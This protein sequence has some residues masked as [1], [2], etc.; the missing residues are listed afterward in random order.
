MLSNIRN[1]GVFRTYPFLAA[2]FLLVFSL[3]YLGWQI[4][5]IGI[6][7]YLTA[8]KPDEF[9]VYWAAW[10]GEYAESMSKK[11]RYPSG[12][13]EI[14]FQIH[15]YNQGKPLRLDPGT[16]KNGI[17]IKGVSFSRFGS[18]RFITG[19]QLEDLIEKRSDA[20][21][22]TSDDE[23]EVTFDAVDPQLYL[24]GFPEPLPAWHQFCALVLTCLLFCLLAKRLLGKQTVFEKPRLFG[25]SLA[26]TILGRL[27]WFPFYPMLAISTLLALTGICVIFSPRAVHTISL[28]S[29]SVKAVMITGCFLCL[30]GYPLLRAV[31]PGSKFLHAAGSI[32]GQTTS[33]SSLED[34]HSGVKKAIKELDQSFIQLF[35]FR[36]DLLNLNATIK[37]FGLGFSPTSKA[38]LGKDGMFFEGYG[39][40]RVEGSYIGSFDNITDYMGLIPFTEAEL[41]EWRVCLEER[42]YWLK[43]QGSDYLFALAPSKALVYPEKLPNRI[44]KIKT[45]LKRPTRYEQLI[46]YLK[47]YSVVPVVDLRAVFANVK[48]D[49]A[50]GKPLSDLPLYYRTDF[51]WTYYG[52]F[53]A[54]QAILEQINSVY[55]KYQ[56]EPQRLDEFTIKVIHDWVH[57]RFIYALGLKPGQHQNE[58][59]VT[60]FP[61]PGS[62]LSTVAD[63]AEKGIDDYSI[64]Q[65]TTKMYGDY[66][67]VSRTIENDK[68]KTN[69]IFVIG[70]SFAEK[71]FGFFSAHAK[72]TVNF[73]TVFSFSP[74]PFVANAPDLV[75][76]EL[77]N[78]FLLN[79]PPSNP[80]AIKE[81]RARAMSRLNGNTNSPL[82]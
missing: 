18:A 1:T 38:I 49:A 81:A 70:D 35:P 25:A 33:K 44:F 22:T 78:M 42:Y 39:Q 12:N 29:G 28:R 55:P 47:K 71:Y 82:K 36:S 52:A 41:E 67:F 46:D 8:D 11:I 26:L 2:F 17:T 32:I 50:P 45:Q 4:N 60:F 20:R 58:T 23:L 10:S 69:R 68:A 73:R 79:S 16:Q 62:V 51:H 72:K 21:V 40:R 31:T 34:M 3:S 5:S 19:R 61:K 75:I 7:I 74:E 53:L 43:E 65:N 6:K 9:A 13:S 57:Y 56:F 24:S 54:Y 37:I 64:P 77:L 59:Y 80:A 15:S 14:F 66:K 30:L 27:L 76:Q 63:F 48:R